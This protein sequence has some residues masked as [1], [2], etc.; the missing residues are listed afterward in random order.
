MHIDEDIEKVRNGKIS[1][2]MKLFASMFSVVAILLVSSVISTLEYTRMSSY[3]TDLVAN[4][5]RNINTAGHL[6]EMSNSYNLAILSVIGDD[7]SASV[8]D[9]DDNYFKS[10]CDSLRTSLSS[11]AVRTL[12]DSVLYSYSAYMLTSME[13]ENVL[14]SD[15][16]DSRSWFFERL[17]P[18]YERLRRDIDALTTSIHSDLAANSATFERG[19]S[20]S[21]IPGTVAVGAG[22]LLVIL[23]LFFILSG[24]V[25]PIYKMLTFLDAYRSS[26][27]KYTYTFEGD[28]QL[29]ELNRGISE[30]AAENQTLRKRIADLKKMR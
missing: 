6:Q 28:D 13:L 8:P 4:D 9:F 7:T 17:Q 25:N 18:R 29:A 30:L 20:R 12:A 5:I 23:L 15:F 1:M 14:M 10:Y 3:V 26:D 19:Y 21:V 16:I 2:R 24:Y 27:K 11:P 22:I